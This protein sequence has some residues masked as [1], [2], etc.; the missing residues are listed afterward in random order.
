MESRLPGL[1]DD[2]SECVA[3]TVVEVAITESDTKK[4][5]FNP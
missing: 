5:R 1:G 4:N 2:R 3:Q